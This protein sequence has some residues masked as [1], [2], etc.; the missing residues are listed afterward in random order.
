LQN[1]LPICRLVPYQKAEGIKI[2]MRN[3]D[4]FSCYYSS[5]IAV[6]PRINMRVANILNQQVVNELAYN[7]VMVDCVLSSEWRLNRIGKAGNISPNSFSNLVKEWDI[8]SPS[9]CLSPSYI[10]E[11]PAL[12]AIRKVTYQDLVDAQALLN[13]KPINS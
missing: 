5:E 6:V 12:P 10:K 3:R 1:R 9:V 7:E 4:G 11:K 8:E 13:K 2:L